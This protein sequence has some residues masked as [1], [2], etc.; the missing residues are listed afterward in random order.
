MDKYTESLI[1]F[2][3][4]LRQLC[5]RHNATIYAKMV[6]VQNIEC[7]ALTATGYDVHLDHTARGNR[8]TYESDKNG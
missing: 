1:P 8:T 5:F 6:T 7:G 3:N 2:C 4:D